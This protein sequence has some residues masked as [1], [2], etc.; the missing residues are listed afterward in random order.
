MGKVRLDRLLV[1]RGLAPS[2]EKAQ[3]LVLAGQVL[4]ND[5]RV[6]KPGTRVPEDAV[7]T[8]QGTLPYVSRGGLK[9]E[10]A[11]RAFGLRV[12]G[13]ACLDVGASTGGFTD[14]LLQHGARRVYAVDVGRGQLDWRLRQDPRVAVMEG[15]NARYPYDLPE[16]VDL[17]TVDVSFISLTKVLPETARHLRP[18]GL[19]LALVKP[20]F[21]AERGEVGKGGVIRDPRLHARILGRVLLWAIRQGFR[22]RGLTPSPLLGDAGNRE[23]FLL[24]E[25][26]RPRYAE[27]KARGEPAKG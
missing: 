3:A 16:P 9:L 14:C 8:L 20:P 12:E 23:F 17:A 10:H 27:G 25:V 13:K 24:L 15:V 19:I 2:R 22:V 11:L 7:L 21:E 6:D 18:G 4:V 5:R 26:P 1:E